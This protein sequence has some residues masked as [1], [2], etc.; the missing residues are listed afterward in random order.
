LWCI[1]IRKDIENICIE[2][3]HKNEGQKTV[4]ALGLIFLQGLYA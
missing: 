1:W 2:D 3:R 4:Q